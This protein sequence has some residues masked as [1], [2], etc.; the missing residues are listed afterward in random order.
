MARKVQGGHERTCAR[1]K[2]QEKDSAIY[3]SQTAQRLLE[4]QAEH[5]SLVDFSGFS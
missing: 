2:N 3:A 5:A 1:Q 4:R